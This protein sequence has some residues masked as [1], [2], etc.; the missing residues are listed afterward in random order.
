M[1]IVDLHVHTILS[2]G[3]AS[4]KRMIHAA[5]KKGLNGLAF[6]DH[7]N[8]SIDPKILAKRFK[9]Y[10]SAVKPDL[11]IIPGFEFSSRFGHVLALFPSFNV[12]FNFNFPLNLFSLKEFVEEY[13]GV[14]IAAHIFRSSGLGKKIYD[15]K[16][17][18]NAVEI[19]PF[20]CNFDVFR[21]HLPL[22]AGSD[23]HSPFT[24]G[25]AYT[26]FRSYAN[27]P[28]DLFKYIKSN[29]IIPVLRRTYYLRKTIDLIRILHPQ[30]I[31]KFL[32]T[33][34]SP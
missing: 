30:L 23:A 12:N 32:C 3:M 31:F 28:E 10:S 2:D 13:G 15:L 27:S 14:L 11:L 25:F 29:Q 16:E 7:Y 22:V 18:F 21:L 1:F 5:V 26:L 17:V 9:I 24:L 4:P 20:R 19:Y 8:S 33:S 34:R 6:V